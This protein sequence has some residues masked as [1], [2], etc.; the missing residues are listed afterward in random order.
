MYVQLTNYCKHNNVQVNFTT[1]LNCLPWNTKYKTV[2]YHMLELTNAF[3]MIHTSPGLHT[4]H[5]LF[6]RYFRAATFITNS[7]TREV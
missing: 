7:T 2:L 5:A 6:E 1:E 3:V 4:P